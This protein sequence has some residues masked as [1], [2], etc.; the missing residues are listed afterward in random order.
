M[1]RLLT[2]TVARRCPRPSVC[3]LGIAFVWILLR[4]FG[5]E[6]PGDTH[7]DGLESGGHRTNPRERDVPWLNFGEQAAAL[8]AASPTA[9]PLHSHGGEGRGGQRVAFDQPRWRVLVFANQRLD[10]LSRLGRS[11]QMARINES[12]A[13]S[14]LLEANQPP[15]VYAHTRHT[16]PLCSACHA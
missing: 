4:V 9:S 10:S 7:N 14:F 11:L 8:V 16:T 13:L 15:A 3:A 2:V 6:D 1:R 5:S 12:V